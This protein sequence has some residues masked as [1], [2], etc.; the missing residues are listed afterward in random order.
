MRGPNPMPRLISTDLGKSWSHSLTPFGGTGVGQKSAVLRLASG[1][2]L[3]C[4]TDSRKPPIT[5]KRGTFAALSKD[6]G[7]TW[8]HVRHVPN[9]SGYLSVAQAP[10][11]VIYL[12]GTKMSCVTFN[13]AWLREG[14][15][16]IKNSKKMIIIDHVHSTMIFSARLLILASL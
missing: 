6:E 8:V 5:G 14:K 7:N 10:N 4:A 13:E 16:L 11:G 3:L 1:N 15:S 9:V 12:F 2:L